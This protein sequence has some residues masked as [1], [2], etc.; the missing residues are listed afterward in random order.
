MFKCEMCKREFEALSGLGQH[1]RQSHKSE[2][3]IEEY[4]IKYIDKKGKCVECGKDTAFRSLKDGYNRF[5][6]CKCSANS[7]EVQNKRKETCL[8]NSGYE[9]PSQD[10]KVKE[11]KKQT[12]L[13]NSGYE[14]PSQDPKNK[15]KQKQT[16]FENSGYEH[17][18]QDPKVKE[19]KKQTNI[20]KTGYEYP[21]QDPVT[22]K[23]SKQTCLEKTGYEYSSQDP[24]VIEKILESTLNNNNGRH[25]NKL[26]Y[27]QIQEKYPLL[28]KIEELKEG[29]NGEIWGHC[30]N[31]NCKN[32]RENGGYFKLTPGQIYERQ[33]G[34]NSHDTGHFY[35][36][37]ECKNECPLFNK[38]ASALHNL[39]TENK[40]ILYTTAEYNTWKEEVY[41]RQ[42]I[43]NNTE[44]NFC[45]YC[46][47]TENLQVHH[48]IP[49]KI[50][51]G[52]ALD[53]INGII[54]CKDCHYEKGHKAG[55]ECSTSNLANK[56]CK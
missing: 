16:Y 47:T 34:I 21:M 36:C 11:K 54:A 20:K 12:C 46:H 22:R 4:Y 25:P 39:I 1:I 45:E 17:P 31:A 37:Q 42:R 48:E 56:I 9:H 10:P 44:T 30:K 28:V 29:P 5:C 15:E 3:T 7:T 33:R 24:K 43:E 2:I 53:P 41:Y 40:E 23:K 35:C 51:P 38:S 8:E 19:K 6:S 18:S 32:S 14:H 13:E 26:T 49:Q 55:S 50:E 27:Q 52:Y